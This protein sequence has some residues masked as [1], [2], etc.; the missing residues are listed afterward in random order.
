LARQKRCCGHELGLVAQIGERCPIPGNIPG[1][2]GRGSEH[3]DLGEGV[4][5]H[6]RRVR[7]DDL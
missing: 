1:Q 5:A 6:C 4:P 2:V 7:L 3:P